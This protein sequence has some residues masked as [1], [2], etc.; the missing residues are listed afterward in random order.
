MAPVM[1]TKQYTVEERVLLVEEKIK[2]NSHKITKDNYK[3]RFP[4]T[5]RSPSKMTVWKMCRKFHSKGTVSNQNRGNSGR[6]VSVLTPQVLN[7]I[8]DLVDSEKTLP[9]RQSRSSCRRHHLPMQVSKSSFHRGVR[10]LGYHPYK[11]HRRHILKAGDMVKRV[12]MATHVLQNYEENPDW[13]N[14]LWMSDE[15]VFSLNGNVNSKNVVCYSEKGAGR[16]EN[17]CIDLSKH[18]DSVMPWA[19]L[20]G[21]G[22]KLQLQYFEP[23]VIDGE[24][25]SGTMTGA[26]YYKL[27][28]Y[29]AIPEIKS[30]NN[31]SLVNQCWQQDGARP[32]WSAQNLAYLQGQFGT[33]T[34]ALGAAKWGGGE[35]A[36]HSPDLSVL[37]F[38]VW[39]VLKHHVFQHPMPT[40]K[41]QLKDKI[42]L[43][44]DREITP[45]LVN[46]A[47]N[48][49]IKRC[50]NVLD[51]N[52]GHQ[53]EE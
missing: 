28:R 18:A 27:L 36:P 12:R 41:Q 15:A 11:L 22:R 4:L 26:R 32:H 50:R 5:G 42:Q 8:R 48:S 38:C 45:E 14:N 40:N 3:R 10:K 2:K 49:F 52:G 20:A 35:W 9:A 16:P 47:F 6:K 13:I 43:M 1:K 53:D 25:V 21:D 44:W 34:L 30:L 51:K 37:D 46:K 31:G 7:S 17:F 39:G 33:N 24:Q 29:K 23:E 19:C